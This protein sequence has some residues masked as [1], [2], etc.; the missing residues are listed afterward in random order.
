MSVQAYKRRGSFVVLL[1]TLCSFVNF[2][3]IYSLY[4]SIALYNRSKEKKNGQFVVIVEVPFPI[5]YYLWNSDWADQNGAVKSGLST[6]YFPLALMCLS[7]TVSE[8]QNHSCIRYRREAL[9]CPIPSF[10]TPET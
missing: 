6:K 3:D 8:D 1:L 4:F 5:W 10:G 9:S 2:I 7:N